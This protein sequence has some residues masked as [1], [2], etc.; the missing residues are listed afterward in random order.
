MD[1]R[2]L[3]IIVCAL[4]SSVAAAQ[5]VYRHVDEQGNVSYSDQAPVDDASRAATTEIEVDTGANVI[6]GEHVDANRAYTQKMNKERDADDAAMQQQRDSRK[7]AIT[8]AEQ[9]LASAQEAYDQRAEVRPGDFVGKAGG[10]TRPSQ[11]RTDR[12]QRLE[13]ELQQAKTALE[14]ARSGR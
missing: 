2:P 1:I 13:A 8:R 7:A 10:G 11:Q 12:I 14:Q 5:T 3:V 4:S 9:S 6:S